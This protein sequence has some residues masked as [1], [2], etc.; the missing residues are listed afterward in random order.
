MNLSK[1]QF[2]LLLITICSFQFS[3]SQSDFI[4]PGT[5]KINDSLYIDKSPV[6]NIMYQELVNTLKENTEESPMTL[7]FSEGINKNGNWINQYSKNPKYQFFPMLHITREQAEYYCKWR[8]EKVQFLWD[9]KFLDNHKIVLYRLPTAKEYEKAEVY[10]KATKRFKNFEAD[11]P[12]E[13]KI[14]KHP[15]K[16]YVSYN[17]SEITGDDQYFGENWKSETQI[18]LPNTYTGFRCICEVKTK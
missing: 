5:L 2:L 10:F 11:N 16:N 18:I 9:I 6:T 3:V 12:L 1:Q 7:V 4:P 14:K 15:K 17:I 8:S 13:L